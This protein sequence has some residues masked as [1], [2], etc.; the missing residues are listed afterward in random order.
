MEENNM[1]TLHPH[2]PF[3]NHL[4]VKTY[5]FWLQDI[6]SQKSKD[7]FERNALIIE[8]GSITHIVSYQ[9]HT[10]TDFIYEL[11]HRMTNNDSMAGI[12]KESP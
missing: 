6:L 12:V 10:E 2:P 11:S 7:G 1:M 5:S 4:R 9:Y 8:N 3:Q